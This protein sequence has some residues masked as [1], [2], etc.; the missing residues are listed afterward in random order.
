MNCT[1]QDPRRSIDFSAVRDPESI[2]RAIAG[3]LSRR[4]NPMR[5]REIQK[6]FK[7]TPKVAIATALALMEGRGQIKA[8]LT[9]VR[10]GIP[11]VSWRSP[12]N[13]GWDD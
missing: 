2:T 4:K 12:D 5:A 7:A 11:Q 13:A 10:R 9:S 6:W 3:L 1:R 8:T